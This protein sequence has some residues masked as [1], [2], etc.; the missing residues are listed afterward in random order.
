MK[1]FKLAFLGLGL[2]LAAALP[3]AANGGGEESSDTLALW[4]Y[5]SETG[6]M[7]KAWRAAMEE[8]QAM[9]PELTLEFE[10]KGFE[11]IRQTASMVLNSSEAPDVMEY[12]KGNATA[13][14]LSDQGLLTDLTDVAV[15]R[16][17]DKILG[18]SIAMTAMYKDGIMG[19]GAWYGITN[20]GEYVMAYYNKD[21]FAEYGLSVPKTL[22]EFEDVMAAFVA[23]GVT[24]LS[25]G[26]A[27]Y[28]AQ[29]VF[30]ELVLSQADDD[31]VK[32]FQLFQGDVDFQGPEFTFAAE[33]MV[34]WVDKGYIS[35][36]AVSMKAEEMGLAFTSGEY[37][38]MIS[39]SWWY[40][41]FMEEITSFDWGIFNFPGNR[42]HPGSSGNLWVVPEK[43][44]NKEIAYDF[45]DITLSPKIQNIMGN[46]GGIPVNADLSGIT[47]PKV[48]EL[49]EGFN[50]ILEDNGL[51]FYPDWPVA[52]YYDVLVAKVQDLIG[53]TK[54]P[55]TVLSEMEDEYYAGR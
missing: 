47:N 11:Q 22:D 28:P 23:K 46:E 39:G 41:R 50:A 15:E 49:I 37:P 45:I 36:V 42:F 20:Y 10:S 31:F 40:G 48:K 53:K 16:G 19:D 43:A 51:A 26:A 34:D 27:E 29:Q 30:Y 52:G 7:G 8:L 25:V 17:W 13:G 54:S 33:K 3:L 9:H 4:H 21:M 5:E 18:E 6:A 1:F 12:N 14:M 2:L 38:I 35:P 55:E 44:E 32:S 24:P